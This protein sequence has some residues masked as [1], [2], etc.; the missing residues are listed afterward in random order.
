[1]PWRIWSGCISAS[2]WLRFTQGSR[3]LLI[4]VPASPSSAGSSVIAAITET[5]TTTADAKPMRRDGRDAGDD[6]T[7]DRDHDRGAGE[8]DGHAG[9]AVGVA[10]RVVR[11]SCP[12]ASC[13][14]CRVTT[15]SA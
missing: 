12:T 3:R 7:A 5:A 15:N 1:M 8:H 4:F 11:R 14:R 2:T 10:G 13:S 9:R 6:E